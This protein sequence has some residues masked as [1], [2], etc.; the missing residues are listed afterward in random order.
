MQFAFSPF[1][2]S[3]FVALL[4]VIG[5]SGVSGKYAWTQWAGESC[6]QI[7]I[8]CHFSVAFSVTCGFFCIQKINAVDF[9]QMKPSV[10]TSKAL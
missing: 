8:C 6:T 4:K 1:S 3:E 9:I 5:I 7:F 2:F 10:L